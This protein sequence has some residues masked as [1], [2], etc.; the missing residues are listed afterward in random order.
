MYNCF[1]NNGL[2]LNQTIPNPIKRPPPILGCI[3]NL[4]VSLSQQTTLNSSFIP[5]VLVLVH[6]YAVE[7]NV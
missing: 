4:L 7:L 3:P 1:K 2:Y 5:I 6:L